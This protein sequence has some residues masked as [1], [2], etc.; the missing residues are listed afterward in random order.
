MSSLILDTIGQVRFNK[1]E[2]LRLAASAYAIIYAIINICH[3]DAEPPPS[4][5]RSIGQFFE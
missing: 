1:E 3:K 2:A 4:I 5:V